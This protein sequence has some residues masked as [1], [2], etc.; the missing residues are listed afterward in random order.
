MAKLGSLFDGIGGWPL[1]AIR[2]GIEPVWAS[3]IEKLPIE[4]TKRHFPN[5]KHLGDIRSINGAQIE[6]VDIIT[7]G[8]P[9]QDM[10]T[11]G[12]RKGLEGER[13]GLFSESTRIF[14]EMRAATGGKYPRFFV[15]ENVPGAFSS[16]HRHDFR[17]VLEEIAET[18]IP[19]PSTGKWARAGMVGGGKCEIAWRTLDAQYWGVPQYRKR[20]FLVADFGGQCA[21]KILFES[22]SL[23]RNFAQGGKTREGTAEVAERSVRAAGFNHKAAAAA[24]GI[25]CREEQ[26][27]TL[28]AECAPAVL[29]YKLQAFGKYKRSDTASTLQQRDYKS[30]AD[31]IVSAWPDTARALTARHDGSPC[32]DRDTNFI[33][34]YDMT[35]ADEVMRE[36]KGGAVQTLNERMG[37]GG[38]QVPVIHETIPISDKATRHKG[39]GDERKNDGAGNGLGVGKAGDPAPTL[40]AADRHAAACVEKNP[41]CTAIDCRNL[42]EK[43]VSTTLQSKNKGYSLNYINPV[44]IK[45]IVRRLTPKECERLQGLPDGW[46]DGGSDSARY[47]AI[48]NGMAQP[49]ADYVMQGIAEELEG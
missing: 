35:H 11:A 43:T 29:A 38:N 20:I 31:L 44:R 12:K 48:G 26:S 13:S 40:T 34:I 3:E 45:T 42:K 10:S 49:C 32:I 33:A 8:S 47:K 14:R 22:E 46:T 5:M 2:S 39:G 9:C 18:K 36:V 27:P 17:T 16:N 1:T 19:M 15:W 37:T 30:A 23:R 25:G 7:S 41:T 28:K 21:G 4:V 6:P 24:G